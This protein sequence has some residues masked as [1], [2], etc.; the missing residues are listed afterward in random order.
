V[1]FAGQ[2]SGQA[3]LGRLPNAPAASQQYGRFHR[4][5]GAKTFDTAAR[6]DH[7]RMYAQ[8]TARS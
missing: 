8:R 2:Q 4:H 7:L 1:A 5:G 6:Q 3:I